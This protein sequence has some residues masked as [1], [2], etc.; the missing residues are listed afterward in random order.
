MP[1]FQ[2]KRFEQILAQ[3]IAKIVARTDLSDV[4]DTSAVKHVLAAAARSD[5]EQYYQM[6]LLLKLFSIDTAAGD[7]LDARAKDIQPGT[8]FRM[9]A[10]KSSGQVIF[11]RTGTSGTV[12]IPSGTK[13]KTA[14][15]QI[16]STTTTVSI[17]PTSPQ[18]IAGHGV[19]RDS[20]AAAAT[21]DQ[22]GSAG[23]VASSTIV[24][25]QQKPT[26]VD[27]VVNPD[28][29]QNGAD[30]ES[31]DSF[32]QRLKAFV[33]GLARCTVQA[34]EANVQGQQ[35]PVTGAVA[36]FVKV[37]EDLLDRGNVTVYID[38]GTGSA[39]STATVS[40]ENLTNG[41]SGPPPNSAVGGEQYLYF[42]NKPI[43]NAAAK[44]ITSSTR[45]VLTQ[46]VDYYLNAPHGQFY[47]VTPL[48]TG[49]V[50]T[51]DYTYY[52]GLIQFV[53]KLIDGDPADRATYPGL[54]AAG[55]LAAVATPQIM[56]QTVA[57]TITVKDGYVQGDVK[58]AVKEAVKSYINSLGI[59]GDVIKAE[60]SKRMMEVDGVYNLSLS[61]PA[62][63]VILL[64]DQL[65]R[66]TDVN[67]VI[68]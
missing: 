59:S 47:S 18:Q 19:G 20:N 35:D 66:T 57:A 15:G 65:A 50:I 7:D 5:D 1:T 9:Q 32:R 23:N 60:L 62:S 11:T 38:D 42:D 43:N 33:A 30:K 29:F 63:D 46:N 44:T 31:D 10:N 27:E 45:G 51:A 54:R 41:L 4:A 24:S 21:A 52:T 3:M 34:I 53:Q 8:L 39:E 2:P 40:G 55:I 36:L 26:G 58:T 64:D 16:F 22:A 12:T 13:V 56:I 14:S 68:S 6:S 61:T 17:T 48:V 49:E 28:P 25:F 37:I 67:I